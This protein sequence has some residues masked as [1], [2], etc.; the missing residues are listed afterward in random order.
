M[1]YPTCGNRWQHPIFICHTNP[2]NHPLPSPPYL[3]LPSPLLEIFDH[4]RG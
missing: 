1:P 2:L 3:P 4:P